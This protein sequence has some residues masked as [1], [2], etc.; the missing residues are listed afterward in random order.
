MMQHRIRAAVIVIEGE[1][2]LLVQHQHNDI[3]EGQSW[4][5]PPGG[6]VE[7]EESLLE[8]ARRETLEETG[9]SVELDRIAYI[10]EFVEPGYHHC[11][12]FFIAA[13]YSGTLMTG[14]NPGA[15]IFDVDHMIKDVRFVPR[16]EMAGMTIY[17]EEVKTLLWGD[18]DN[19][20][21]QVRYLG[22]QHS[23]TKTYLDG[24][25]EMVL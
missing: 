22:V 25:E 19:G 5:V 4:W 8:C 10:R 21:T 12:V 6:G 1:S 7:G 3:H 13:S 14:S 23:E 20:F 17:P 24:Q 15:G 9:L 16:A 18:L 2:A 11:E